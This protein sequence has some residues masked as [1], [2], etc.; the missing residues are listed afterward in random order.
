MPSDTYTVK[1]QGAQIAG[2][3]TILMALLRDAH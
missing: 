3:Q 1:L 2:F